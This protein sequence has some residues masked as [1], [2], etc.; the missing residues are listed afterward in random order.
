MS[1]TIETNLL[2]CPKCNS[3]EILKKNNYILCQSCNSKYQMKNEKYY[4][5]T[6]DSASITDNLDRFKHF[7][8]RYKKI[9]AFLIKTISPV[10]LDNT[11][12]KFIE[13]YIS[14]DKIALNIGSG[15]SDLSKNITNVDIFAYDSVNVVC[16]ITN[17][18]FKDN[19]IDVVLNIAVLEHVQNPQVVINEIYRVLKPN[20]KI[21]TAFPFIQGFHASPYDFTRVTYE[22]IK[23][24]HRDFNQ[25]EVIPYGG[26]TSGFLWVMQEWLTLILSFGIKKIH[27]PIY[28]F[29]MLI[30]FPI[31]FLDYV[32]IKHPMAK[33]ISSGF[34]F[35]GEKKDDSF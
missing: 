17:L 5:H 34:I 23:Y 7:I 18:P 8:K 26:P 35:I 29:I 9:Y 21:Y 3:N 6:L 22:G 19:S 33:N 24:L 10:Y 15:Y 14:S 20:G 25:I 28:I 16:D 31:K 27:T 13:K 4:F 30:T 11:E 2:Q 1:K 32:L 12:E